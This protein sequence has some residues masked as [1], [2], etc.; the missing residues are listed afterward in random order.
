[1]GVGQIE[2]DSKVQA[3]PLEVQLELVGQ[4]EAGSESE[5]RAESP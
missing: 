2:S 3:V 5:S 4:L 1:M